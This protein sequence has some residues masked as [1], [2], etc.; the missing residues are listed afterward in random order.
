MDNSDMNERY[1]EINDPILPISLTIPTTPLKPFQDQNK[2]VT[3]MVA[4]H[5]KKSQQ[6]FD[7]THN[8]AL[9][10][11]ILV[12]SLRE[13]IELHKKVIEQ[14]ESTNA[15]QKD[16]LNILHNLF[17]S[18]ED[19]AIVVKAIMSIMQTQLDDASPIKDF[20]LDKGT[21]FLMAV[22]PAIGKY[23]SSQGLCL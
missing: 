23:L 20:V 1:T 18:N 12:K 3:Q 16:Q 11:D 19:Q 9:N 10:T 17:A 22:L 14:L 5:Y 2:A 4:E 8:I 6:Q 7:D 15:Q 21:D 13:Q